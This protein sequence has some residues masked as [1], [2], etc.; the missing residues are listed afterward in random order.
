MIHPLLKHLLTIP[1]GRGLFLL[2]LWELG[3]KGWVERS[4]VVKAA[5]F[6]ECNREHHKRIVL[7]LVKLGFIESEIQPNGINQGAAMVRITDSGV[8]WLQEGYKLT[9]DKL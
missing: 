3:G 2:A 4:K 6:S 5:L 9:K 1:K 8:A 7:D